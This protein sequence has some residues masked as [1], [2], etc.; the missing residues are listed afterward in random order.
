MFSEGSC[1]VG[2]KEGD[3]NEIK[4]GKA[5]IF[6][7]SAEWTVLENSMLEGLLDYN[8]WCKT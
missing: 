3:D 7:R 5:K 2:D 1:N 8:C 6:I 4:I